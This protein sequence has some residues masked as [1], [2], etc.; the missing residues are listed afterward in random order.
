MI[1][2]G[3]DEEDKK[4]TWMDDAETVSSSIYLSFVKSPVQMLTTVSPRCIILSVINYSGALVDSSP[5]VQRVMFLTPT[6]TQYPCCVRN[7]S[8]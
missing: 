3:V 1:G 4:R 8:E 7:T 6:L 2:V 5:F